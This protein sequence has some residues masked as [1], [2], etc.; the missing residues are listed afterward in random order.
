MSLSG[1]C[2]VLLQSQTTATTDRKEAQMPKSKMPI[3]STLAGLIAVLA[4]A[5]APASAFAGRSL[6]GQ[7]PYATGCNRDQQIAGRGTIDDYYGH[8]FGTIDLMWSPRCQT[9]WGI[10]YFNDGNPSSDPAV[11]IAVDGT[12]SAISPWLYNNPINYSTTAPGSPVW[13]NMAYSPGCAK[14]HVFFGEA[15]GLAVQYGCVSDAG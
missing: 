5:G 7:D 15:D 11:D 10:A 4:L 12:D 3:V 9:N 6:N 14:A 2:S 13:G 1:G 8:T